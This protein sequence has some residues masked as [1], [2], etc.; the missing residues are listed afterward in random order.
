MSE[1][2]ADTTESTEPTETAEA[3]NG[4]EGETLQ[5][6]DDH[7]L[8][9]TLA[10]QKEQIKTL[11]ERTQRLD[12]IEESQKSEADKAAERLTQAEQ[13]ATEA[14]ARALRR[15]V[16]LDHKLTK[17]DAALLDSMTDEDAMRALAERLAAVSD[18]KHGNYVPREGNNPRPK[19]DERRAFADFLTGNTA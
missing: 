7:P 14:E 8:V 13:R 15:E 11:K 10:A 1:E 18:T 19:P 6:P 4:G 9:K 5:L 17:D 12:E 2:T 3:P 16:A